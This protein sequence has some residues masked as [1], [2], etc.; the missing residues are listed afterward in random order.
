MPVLSVRELH[1]LSYMMRTTG[2]S[3]LVWL[4]QNNPLSLP[5]V[6]KRIG[7]TKENLPLDPHKG[8]RI[9]VYGHASYY[10]DKIMANVEPIGRSLIA[11]ILNSYPNLF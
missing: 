10:M 1:V 8:Y 5:Y 3:F 2:V 9:D 11:V 7:L 4:G 6:L